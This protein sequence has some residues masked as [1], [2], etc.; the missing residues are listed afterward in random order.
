MAGVAGV[1]INDEPFPYG[2]LKPTSCLVAHNE[3]V[4]LP[5][6]AEQLDWE[7]EL[8]VVIGDPSL[9]ATDDP[10]RAVFGYSVF[11]DLS[12]RDFI[13]FPHALGFDTVVG[14]GF[15]G[16]APMGPWI[17]LAETVADVQ[18]LPIHLRVNGKLEQESS[19]DRMIFP[20]S[21]VVRH[22]ARVLQL[23]PGDVISTGTPAGVG[24][25]NQPPRFLA[26]GDTVEAE[27]G[28]LGRLRTEIV[29]KLSATPLGSRKSSSPVS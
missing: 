3:P 19:T 20:V 28:G 1:P 17:T 27:I 5:S 23:S 10:L 25:G 9:A 4:P 7:A 29:A 12:V 2:F 8:A 13:P 21:E 14:K 16:S 22:F 24:A 15:P 18:S 11:N 26:A 6:F